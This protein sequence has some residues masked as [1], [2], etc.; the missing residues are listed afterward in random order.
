MKISPVIS[1]LF[2]V[3]PWNRRRK[4]RKTRGTQTKPHIGPTEDLWFMKRRRSTTGTNGCGRWAERGKWKVAMENKA[5]HARQYRCR[6]LQDQIPLSEPKG[7]FFRSSP[8]FPVT[9]PSSSGTQLEFGFLYAF[10]VDPDGQLVLRDLAGVSLERPEHLDWWVRERSSCWFSGSSWAVPSLRFTWLWEP[11]RTECSW[12]TARVRRSKAWQL[13]C[14]VSD[15]RSVVAAILSPS[16][17]MLL[18]LLSIEVAANCTVVLSS[19]KLGCLVSCTQAAMRG[20]CLGLGGAV[21]T[22]EVR[23]PGGKAVRQH[24]G[25]LEQHGT[26][27]QA[28]DVPCRTSSPRSS[29]VVTLS[30]KRKTS[31]RTNKNGRKERPRRAAFL[32]DQNRARHQR[33][34]PVQ[35]LIPDQ[36]GR[37]TAL[38]TDRTFANWLTAGEGAGPKGFCRPRR[39]VAARTNVT[40]GIPDT[41][42]GP[43]CTGL[44]DFLLGQTSQGVPVTVG[45]ATRQPAALIKGNVEVKRRRN[46]WLKKERFF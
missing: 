22:W 23:G 4:K 3:A 28:G 18:M 16:T 38:M 27:R 10:P 2:I 1:C 25:T 34:G 42:A 8:V 9:L 14:I 24:R 43:K 7:R 44:P 17:S 5:E 40:P 11:A 26:W 6:R 29:S 31:V 37:L 12:S 46:C 15:R 20:S 39:R 33:C 35:A 36:I 13:S 30:E 45:R 19:S 32:T 41:R 21:W